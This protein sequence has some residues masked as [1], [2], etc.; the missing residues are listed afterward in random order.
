MDL[1]EILDATLPVDIEFLGKTITLN[2]FTAG[3]GRLTKEQR[4][5]FNHIMERKAERD[6]K[7]EGLIAQ[8]ETA[9]DDDKASLRAQVRE[10][11]NDVDEVSLAREVLPFIA[12][13]WDEGGKPLTYHDKHFPE[14]VPELP[15]MLL[16]LASSAAIGIW[17]NPTNGGQ[18]ES[19]SPQAEL[20]I[21]ESSQAEG[22]T[23]P[24]N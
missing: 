22:I 1:E 13:G 11:E 21:P 4:L 24:A 15:D 23:L 12:K 18:E 6:A 9:S 7:L 19:G 10:A 5:A 17:M 3:A 2:V 20:V 8:L 16:T 14:C